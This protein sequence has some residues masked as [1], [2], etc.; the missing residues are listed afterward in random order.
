[1]SDNNPNIDQIRAAADMLEAY[2]VFKNDSGYFFHTLPETSTTAPS[3][4]A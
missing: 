3:S 1:M 2:V 4:S